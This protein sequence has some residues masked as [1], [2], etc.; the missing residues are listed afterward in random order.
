MPAARPERRRHADADRQRERFLEAALGGD[1]AGAERVVTDAVIAGMPP[2]TV[3]AEIIAPAMH[4]VGE[5][6]AREEIGVADEHLATAIAHGV[7]ARLYPSLLESP[8][9]SRPAVLVA[10][11]EGERHALGARMVADTLEGA[12]HR[13]LSLGADVPTGALLDAVREHRPAAVLLSVTLR[14][15][16]PVL[17]DAL[18][19]LRE[20]PER[21]VLVVGGQGV[22]PGWRAPDE[23]LV[24]SRSDE[25]PAAVDAAVRAWR[26]R[27]ESTA[28]SRDPGPPVPSMRPRT[29]PERRPARE[30]P[31]LAEP[32][33]AAAD[34]AMAAADLARD[35]A[36]RAHA[37]ESLAFRDPLTGAWN[38]RALDD[39][40]AEIVAAMMAGAHPGGALAVM[41]VDHFKA[42]NDADGHQAGDETLVALARAAQGAVREV[43]LVARLGGDEFVALL[44]GVTLARARQ[45]VE[46]IRAAAPVPVSIGVAPLEVDA[47]ATLMAADRALYEAKRG[48]RDRVATAEPV[49]AS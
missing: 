19:A 46:R 30:D 32:A 6:W 16:M 8:A 12:G 39:R 45:V 28:P 9:N 20:L 5:R 33:A 31:S 36:R 24:V 43:D 35:Y 34:A 21:P 17:S 25:A 18:D 1:T 49:T 42:I 41:D 38:R 48:G 27:P 10:A 14:Q 44:P 22:P 2:A 11:V 7:L 37:L 4:I 40:L 26:G 23:V 47:R 3:L 13:V 29:G 15:S